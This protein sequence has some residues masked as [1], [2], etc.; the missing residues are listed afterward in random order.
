MR[1]VI[2]DDHPMMRRAL[3]EALMALIV[4]IDIVEA[5]SLG[6]T[7]T[8]LAARP[9]QL[10]LLD[11][12]MPGMNGFAGLL[13]LRQAFP[14]VPV[15]VVSANEEPALIRRAIEFGASGYIP[16]SLPIAA[17]GAALRAV[18]AGDIWVPDTLAEL[19]PGEDDSQLSARIADLTPQQL[20]VLTLLAEG[21]HNK[22]IAFEMDITEA[23]V[24][25]HLSQ[26]FR[27]LAVQSR[28][29]AVIAAQSL[30]LAGG[31]AP[32]AGI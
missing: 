27:K 21:K 28:T 14:A 4:S 16:K 17:I 23:T 25:F 26:I 12:Y 18:L 11:L 19:R 5:G 24:K 30:R 1:I 9:A 31:E 29:Q 10:L 8:A 7:E 2:S 32:A 15:V 13:S 20:R 3:A 22:Q 6:E